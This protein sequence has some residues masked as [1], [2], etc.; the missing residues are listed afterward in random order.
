M[1]AFMELTFWYKKIVNKYIN[2]CKKIESKQIHNSYRL[3]K[4]PDCETKLT[5][6]DQLYVAL[7]VK[8]SLVSVMFKVI[9]ELGRQIS[10]KWETKENHIEHKVLA[11]SSN[12]KLSSIWELCWWSNEKDYSKKL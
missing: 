4:L 1:P 3:W 5:A 8:T 11:I 12:T 7:S 9:K 10:R 2:K 6:K